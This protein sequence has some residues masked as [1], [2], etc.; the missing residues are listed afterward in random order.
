MEDVLVPSK[1]VPSQL[2]KAKIVEGR[3]FFHFM[4][5]ANE[6]VLL[7]NTF[8]IE[9]SHW[10]NFILGVK[11]GTFRRKR[12]TPGMKRS[13]S[14]GVICYQLADKY[15]ELT[16]SLDPQGLS[17][18]ISEEKWQSLIRLIKQGKFDLM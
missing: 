7:K 9:I 5:K 16:Y 10:Q 13:K 3:V 11:N 15:M 6:E 18:H 8:K 4:K 17:Y 12:I 14:V 2:F 1:V